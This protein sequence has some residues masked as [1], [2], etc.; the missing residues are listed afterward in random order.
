[1][2]VRRAITLDG[3]EY[4]PGKRFRIIREGCSLH[5]MVPMPQWSN[6]WAGWKQELHVGD[7]IECTGFGP[8]WGAD[9]GYGIEFTSEVAKEAAASHATFFPDTG[10]PFAYRP[11]TGYM[12]EV[13]E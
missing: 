6:A 4:V 2:N 8:G 5:G 1:M 7:I 12:E 13:T 3:V 11:Q 9:P 10:V